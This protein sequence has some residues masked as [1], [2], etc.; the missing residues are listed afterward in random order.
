MDYKKLSIMLFVFALI[1]AI[2]GSTFA[3]W[4]WQSTSAQKTDITF[5]IASGFS[6][7]ADGGGNLTSSNIQ[8]AP[9]VCTNS[10]YAIKRTITTNLTNSGSEPVYMDMW[11][12]VDYLLYPL[13]ESKNFKYALTTSSTNCTTGA[14]AQ[15]NFYQKTPGDKVYLLKDVTSGGT[16]YL[17]IWLDSAETNTAL[18]NQNFKFSLGGECT[19]HVSGPDMI[20]TASDTELEIGEPIPTGVDTFDTY[21]E[22]I[23]FLGYPIFNS[24]VIDNGV[25]SESYV[26]FEITSAV[27]SLNQGVT[28]GVYFLKGGDSGTA[29]QDNVGVLQS[30]FG[31]S[32]TYCSGDSSSYDCQLGDYYY[33][34]NDEGIVMAISP[35]P[36]CAV[37]EGGFA[38]CIV[39]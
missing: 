34:A 26:G 36:Y 28:A 35:S 29:F 20:Y 32:S 17:W 16:Y 11:L 1:F 24:H 37:T 8:L 27:A 7:S 22:A 12:N 18:M 10:T 2:V 25:V 39:Y 19:N 30:A 13:S 23:S 33:S 14:V 38:A 15:G 3:F 6:C 5:T 9:A 4:S 21:Q 31:T